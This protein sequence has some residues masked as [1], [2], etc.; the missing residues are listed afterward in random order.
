M[1]YIFALKLL[2]D[3][4]EQYPDADDFGETWSNVARYIFE[5]VRTTSSLANLKE[6]KPILHAPPAQSE[7]IQTEEGLLFLFYSKFE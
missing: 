3:F 6:I 7:S 2:S 1:N 5:K 4:Q